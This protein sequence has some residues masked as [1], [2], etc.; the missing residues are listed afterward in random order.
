MSYLLVNEDCT[1][2][3][4]TSVPPVTGSITILPAS[5]TTDFS[6]NG[7][8]I[9]NDI[10]FSISG[11]TNQTVTG[12]VLLLGVLKGN[13]SKVKGN[14]LPVIREDAE[15]SVTISGFVGS[16]ATTFTSTVVV[17]NAGQTKLKGI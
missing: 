5:I 12:G 9:Y 1:L 10:S 8:K 17:L 15:V 4:K 16:V 13:S 11:A 2:G 6:S 7:K 14:L 3:F